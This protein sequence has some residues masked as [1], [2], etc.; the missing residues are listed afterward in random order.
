MVKWNRIEVFIANFFILCFL[1]VVLFGFI[2]LKHYND[3]VIDFGDNAV[4]TTNSTMSLSKNNA[5]IIDVFK[6]KDGTKAVLLFKFDNMANLSTDA[7]NYRLFLTATSFSMKREPLISNPVGGL[8][9]FGD[10]GYMAVYLIDK[11]G[12][13]NQILDLIIRQNKSLGVYD[14]VELDPKDFNDDSFYNFDQMKIYFN[15]Y[16]KKAKVAEFLETNTIDVYDMYNEM[17]NKEQVFDLKDKLNKKLYEMHIDMERIDELKSKLSR[18]GLTVKSIPDSIAEDTIIATYKGEDLTLTENGQYITKD[19]E[20]ILEKDIDWVL[21]TPYTV[22]GGFDF[23]WR[24]KDIK[25]RILDELRENKSEYDYLKS[26]RSQK[27]N[28]QNTFQMSQVIIVDKNGNDIDF[29]SDSNV[30]KEYSSRL[31]GAISDYTTALSAYFN[32]KYD[33]QVSL[34]GG[35]IDLE[36]H[37]KLANIEYTYADDILKTY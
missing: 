31:Q 19:N 1:F 5:E 10:S 21:K 28:S 6:S 23:D 15:P 3:S 35:L 7:K 29:S 8:Y 33:Y 36:L 13:K 25:D 9:V 24:N 17:I 16:G 22:K 18:Y 34:L 37:S 30:L 26:L 14:D 27:E 12:I 20:V 32:N 2:G 4:Y 11:S